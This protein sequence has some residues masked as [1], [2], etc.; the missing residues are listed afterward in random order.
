MQGLSLYLLELKNTVQKFYNFRANFISKSGIQNADVRSN[1]SRDAISKYNIFFFVK[2]CLKYTVKNVSKIIIVKN[3][4][5]AIC[6]YI[7]IKYPPY[8][9][10]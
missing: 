10:Q 2:I 7:A 9:K 3:I 4:V 6:E 5:I 1:M 8:K